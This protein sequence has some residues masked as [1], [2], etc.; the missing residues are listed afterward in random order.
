MEKVWVL[1]QARPNGMEKFSLAVAKGLG[2]SALA[3]CLGTNK[4]LYALWKLVGDKRRTSACNGT[5]G[6]DDYI[7]HTVGMYATW[8]DARD[9]GLQRSH[10]ERLP[11]KR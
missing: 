5:M 10:F 2:A 3:A 9:R 1:N 11:K 4:V 8:W 6:K 7:K